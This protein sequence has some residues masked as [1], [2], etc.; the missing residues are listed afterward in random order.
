M[1][2]NVYWHHA[3]RSATAMYKRLVDG[4]LRGGAFDPAELVRYT[5]EGQLHALEERAPSTLLDALRS[6]RL[7]KRAVECPA[8]EFDD[9]FGD[10]MVHDRDLTVAVEDR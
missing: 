4:A 2:R 10:W 5:D 1:Y 6:R 8:A 9:G 7:Y 3:V